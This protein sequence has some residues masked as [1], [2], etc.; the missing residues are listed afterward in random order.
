MIRRCALL[1]FFVLALGPLWGELTIGGSSQA[2]LQ[3]MIDP[4]APAASVLSGLLGLSPSLRVGNPLFEFFFQGTLDCKTGTGSLN[5]SVDVFELTVEPADFLK[6][7]VGRSQYRPGAAPFLS[8]TNYFSPLGLEALLQG[9]IQDAF[10]PS[11]IVQARMF[12]GDLAAVLTLAPFRREAALPDSSSPWFPRKGFPPSIH[13]G[14]PIEQDLVLEHI[15]IEAAKQMPATPGLMSVCAELGL[16]LP[17]LDLALLYYHGADCAPLFSARFDFP[18]GLFQGYDII[19][20]PVDRTIDSFG[21]DAT[22]GISGLRI[23]V[24]CSYTLSK[25]FLT[26]RLSEANFSSVLG[27]SPCLEYSFGAGY[28]FEAPR[29]SLDAEWKGCWIVSPPEAV[30]TPLLSSLLYGR[31]FLRL[32]EDRFLAGA[33]AVWSL[34]DRSLALLADLTFAPSSELSFQL[35]APFFIG[36]ADTELGQFSDNHLAS[37]A[38]TWKF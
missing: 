2:R 30:M 14:F 15:L 10:L 29:L 9:R 34:A 37:L 33:G 5:L 27:S 22:L 7:V 18:H 11:D 23:W 28:D 21:L 36:S 24:D 38:A 35:L 19:L 12:W 32:W 26:R 16:T 13:I 25:V 20:T 17:I 31:A 8:P 3:A 6:I 4:A 1:L